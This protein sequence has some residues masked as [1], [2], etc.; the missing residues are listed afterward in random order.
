MLLEPLSSAFFS[1]LTPSLNEKEEKEEDPKVKDLLVSEVPEANGEEVK[2]PNSKEEVLVGGVNWNPPPR[3]LLLL[4][5]ILLLLLSLLT[6]EGDPKKVGKDEEDKSNLEGGSNWND[7]EVEIWG[8]LVFEV[9]EDNFNTLSTFGVKDFFTPMVSK[10]GGTVN[11][12]LILKSKGGAGAVAKEVIQIINHKKNMQ[13]NFYLLG[14]LDEL[15]LWK[16]PFPSSQL[17]LW[18][19]LLNNF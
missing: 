8:E 13:C 6:N 2:E 5:L 16:I 1:D 17:L 18:K 14:G 4:L 11:A 7:P 12:A 19:L 3:L 15:Y 10:I 9:L